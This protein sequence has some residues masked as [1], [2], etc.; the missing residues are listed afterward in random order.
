MLLSKSLPALASIQVAV[1]YIARATDICEGCRNPLE[2]VSPHR[3]AWKEADVCV[4]AFFDPQ[5]RPEDISLLTD[6]LQTRQRK[7]RALSPNS[8][9]SFFCEATW[10]VTYSGWCLQQEWCQMNSLVAWADP[11]QLFYIHG[12]SC[13]WLCHMYGWV[14]LCL[15]GPFSM[16]PLKDPWLGIFRDGHTIF[17]SACKVIIGTE[18]IMCKCKPLWP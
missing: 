17:L 11:P 8:E 14:Q 1:L 16:L 4:N 10:I 15:A 7:H 9:E 5:I 18:V 12:T 2:P 3:A 6:S 13:Q